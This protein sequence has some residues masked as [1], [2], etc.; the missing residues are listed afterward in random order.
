[1]IMRSERL[2]LLL[3]MALLAAGCGRNLVEVS[4]EEGDPNCADA[5]ESV[6]LAEVGL[7]S[8][9]DEVAEERADE[10]ELPPDPLRLGSD[11]TFE[12]AT[13]NLMNFPASSSTPARVAELIRRMDIDLIAVQEINDTASFR[14]LV[15]DLPGYEGMVL[16]DVCSMGEFQM[17]G[18]VYRASTVTLDSAECIFVGQQYAFPRPPL[19][20]HFTLDEPGLGPVQ[21][22][23]IDVHL[24]AGMS[25]DDESR[26]RAGVELLEGRIA[27]ITDSGSAA[28]VIL[29]GDMNDEIGDPPAYNVFT[30]FL[31]DP[32]SYTFLDAPLA[33]S[34]AFSYIPYRSLIDHIVITKALLDEYGSGPTAVIPLD[35]MGLGFDYE[36]QISD[37]R[38]VVSI[39]PGL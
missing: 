33:V 19:E 15:L 4:C 38:P 23:V 26:R 16:D 18:F 37:H 8:S 34:G 9:T 30:S 7:D 12:I 39:F 21:V 31:E 20:G 27:W 25:A 1:M 11:S 24:K 3:A 28:G 14:T 35:A 32:A 29:L 13:W 6:E 5:V 17:T 2:M 36:T 10:E 22:I